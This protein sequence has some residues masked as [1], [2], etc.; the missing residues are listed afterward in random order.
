MVEAPFSE[1]SSKRWFCPSSDGN[2]IQRHV[3]RCKSG[4][5]ELPMPNQQFG[6]KIHK[7]WAK[8]R[9]FCSARGSQQTMSCKNLLFVILAVSYY[10]LLPDTSNVQTEEVSNVL[11]MWLHYRLSEAWRMTK[12]GKVD[13][14]DHKL[15]HK[16]KSRVTPQQGSPIELWKVC[17]RGPEK[18]NPST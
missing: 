10:E 15:W 18:K 1:K 11:H 8:K 17:W 7:K 12:P 13:C 4:L 3:F 2:F 16:T 6:F 14:S 5:W 9:R